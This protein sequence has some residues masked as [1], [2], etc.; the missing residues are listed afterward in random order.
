M[1]DSGT[2][3]SAPGV[4]G[5]ESGYEATVQGPNAQALQPLLGSNLSSAPGWLCPHGRVLSPSVSSP[6]KRAQ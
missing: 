2:E 4:D 5:W 3:R 6:E 1:H